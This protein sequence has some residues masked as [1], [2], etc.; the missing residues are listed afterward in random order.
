[1]Q[2]SSDDTRY[3]KLYNDYEV[4]IMDRNSK[5]IIT[6]FSSIPNMISESDNTL[7]T[8]RAKLGYIPYTDYTLT[9]KCSG[10]CR[11]ITITPN[12]Y[13]VLSSQWD[14]WR[15]FTLRVTNTNDTVVTGDYDFS[16]YFT[17]LNT[18]IAPNSKDTYTVQYK[19]DDQPGIIL[20]CT[21]SSPYVD[22]STLP[23]NQY[24]RDVDI[25]GSL[26]CQVSLT[27][28]PA[29]NVSITLQSSD[30][31]IHDQ[32]IVFDSWNYNR[33][34]NK[35]FP[36]KFVD[37]SIINKPYGTFTISAST[38]SSTYKASPVTTPPFSRYYTGHYYYFGYNGNT[39]GGFHHSGSV[40]K[41][42]LRKGVYGLRAWGASG[43]LAYQTS[44]EGSIY[45]MN[46]FNSDSTFKCKNSGGYGHYIS[47]RL[48]L[49]A[50]ET[51]YVYVGGAGTSYT[52]S[53]VEAN[54]DKMGGYNGGSSGSNGDSGNRGVG[55]GGA[56]DFCIGHAD[57]KTQSKHYPHRVLVAGGGG[58]AV[59][60]DCTDYPR[61]GGCA[62][63]YHSGDIYTHGHTRRD[64]N[65]VYSYI[66][67]SQTYYYAPFGGRGNYNFTLIDSVANYFGNAMSP[68][69]NS[70]ARPFG[71]G[72]GGYFGGHVNNYTSETKVG[73][74][75][76][77][78]YIFTGSFVSNYDKQISKFK[79]STD[80]SDFS[81]IE[82]HA[83]CIPNLT[84]KRI[85]CNPISGTYVT[86]TRRAGS[87]KGRYGDG[88][89]LIE[90]LNIPL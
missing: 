72:G 68:S 31:V 62:D 81:I 53:Y 7:Y 50:P 13:P 86:D 51:M 11:N 56:T 9:P 73:G 17:V 87:P 8:F 58:G 6:D 49:E 15:E 5:E 35:S 48:T 22:S 52:G 34:V 16:L 54:A 1:M 63:I 66:K 83:T 25:L 41:A 18:K 59:Q 43:G 24:N 20:N 71:G 2:T 27:Q 12:N 69:S 75:A 80:T 36:L 39:S 45:K 70:D 29:E 44:G 4:M 78:S 26:N 33:P 61:S 38:N 42:S 65:D 19:D 40:Q 60:L 55:G 85:T 23:D 14:E 32:S 21:L 47:G 84:T 28:K 82:S 30:G 37:A 46:Q 89:A 3:D 79:L 57:C 10:D 74:G 77:S 64:G 67:N 88:F 90:V 76:G